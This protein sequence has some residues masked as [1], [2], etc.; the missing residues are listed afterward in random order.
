M[1]SFMHFTQSDAEA[2]AGGMPTTY[3]VQVSCDARPPAGRGSAGAR[4]PGTA[5]PGPDSPVGGPA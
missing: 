3:E 2:H 5:P 1:F 4:S